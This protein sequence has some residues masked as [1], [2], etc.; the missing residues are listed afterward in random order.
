M[1]KEN[2]T[3]ILSENIILSADDEGLHIE[4]VEVEKIEVDKDMMAICDLCSE[5]VCEFGKLKKENLASPEKI[6]MA[7]DKG[8]LPV[9]I[10]KVFDTGFSAG[11]LAEQWKKLARSTETDWAL[12]DGCVKEVE[13]V[14]RR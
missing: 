13:S 5:P 4:S 12:C 9:Q 10:L 2:Q 14:L 11:F 1:N 8:L 7:V 6:I 3:E